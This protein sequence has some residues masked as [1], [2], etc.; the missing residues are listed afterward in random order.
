MSKFSLTYW[1]ATPEFKKGALVDGMGYAVSNKS[2]CPHQ[3]DK[4]ELSAQ[5]GQ[6]LPETMQES[7]I[8][9]DATFLN[10]GLPLN[11][12]HALSPKKLF[13][14]VGEWPSVLIS[15]AGAEGKPAS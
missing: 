4:I 1:I 3:T 10:S 14:Q 7:Q 12:R 11:P 5:K 2:P 6:K 13:A 15:V 9:R 8:V